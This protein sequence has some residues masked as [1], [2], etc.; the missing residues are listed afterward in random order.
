M[1]K[2][3][4]VKQIIETERKEST[5]VWDNKGRIYTFLNPVSYLKARKHRDLFRE[6]DGVFADGSLL[7]FAIR[8]FYG[9]RVTRK[10][11]DTTSIA[12][13]VFS[14]AQ[15]QNKTVYIV[16]SRQDQVEKA[17]AKISRH[18]EGIRIVGYRSGYFNSENEQNQEAAHIAKLNPDIL[19]VG[20]G[21]IIQEE[22]VLK[23]REKGYQG[24]SF[25]CGGYISQI[26]DGLINYYPKLINKT[27]T[28]FLYRMYEEP[29]TR[30]RYLKAG[31]V[32]P[33]L[34]FKERLFG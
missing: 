1:K 18:Y 17:V 30:K 19:I 20:M 34:F 26:S 28:R 10:S 9:K 6:F 14:Y 3:E 15:K 16:A 8:F 2:S 27:N 11:F 31:L 29:H 7:V 4:L 32:F 13:L 33:I 12:S 21:I 23:T 22:F 24:V 5:T 25:T